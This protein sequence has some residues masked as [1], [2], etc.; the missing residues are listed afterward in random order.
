VLLLG[1][2]GAYIKIT[3]VQDIAGKQDI[4]VEIELLIISCI[5]NKN[6]IERG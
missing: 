2:A 6:K 5:I 3:Q 4:S 1:I